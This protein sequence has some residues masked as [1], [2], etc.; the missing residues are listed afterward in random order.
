MLC[1]VGVVPPCQRG[2]RHARGCF[3]L[4]VDLDIFLDLV[5]DVGHICQH[6]TL[7]NLSYHNPQEPSATS[8]FDYPFVSSHVGVELAGRIVHEVAHDNFA[9]E[10][11]ACLP[12][13]LVE[14][15]DEALLEM[16]GCEDLCVLLGD[17]DCRVCVGGNKLGAEP[18]NDAADGAVE[19]N[20]VVGGGYH[21]DV[22]GCFTG[23]LT[24]LLEPVVALGKLLVLRA[25]HGAVRV[26]ARPI[27]G[28]PV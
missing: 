14:G 10:H 8:Q 7:T 13:V 18:V 11:T 22:L 5:Q 12:K 26:L 17:L 23:I 6:D 4:E 27:G 20:K 3:P 16:R 1:V 19:D 15:K 24:A 9:L 21:P 2:Y 28:V 25:E